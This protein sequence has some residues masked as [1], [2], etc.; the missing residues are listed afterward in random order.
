MP[1]QILADEPTVDPSQA[2]DFVGPSRMLNRHEFIR[3]L[4]QALHQL[5]YASAAQQ[6]E[7]QSVRAFCFLSL[8]VC[9]QARH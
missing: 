8:S 7:Q 2:P 5:G 4:E 6:L 3:L 9:L 1:W